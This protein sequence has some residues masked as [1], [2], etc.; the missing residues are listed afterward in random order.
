MYT[1]IYRYF[2]LSRLLKVFKDFDKQLV[3]S[4]PNI[5][6]KKKSGKRGKSVRL[7]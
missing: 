6:L 7:S 3:F 1:G 5:R 2:I 4:S